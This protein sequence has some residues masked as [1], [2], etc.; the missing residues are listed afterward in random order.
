MILIRKYNEI[1][2]KYYIKTFTPKWRKREAIL[3][4][5]EILSILLGI[6]FILL[7]IKLIFIN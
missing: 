2:E 6:P 7:M 3:I 5:L 4:T 1:V